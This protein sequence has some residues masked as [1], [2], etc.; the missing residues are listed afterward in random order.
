MAMTRTLGWGIVG[1]GTTML[2][3]SVVRRAMHE[4]SGAPRLPYAL[5]GNNSFAMMLAL[6]VATGALLALGDV[7]LEQRKRVVQVA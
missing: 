2:A 1:A 5:Q 7:L 3:R 4:Q 6:A